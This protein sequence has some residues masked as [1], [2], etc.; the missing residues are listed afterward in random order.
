MLYIFKN[1]L[2]LP[3]VKAF[4][5]I[6]LAAGLPNGSVTLARPL[7]VRKNTGFS[8]NRGERRQ[9]RPS[10]QYFNIAIGAAVGV[11]GIGG[12]YFMAKK[13]ENGERENEYIPNNENEPEENRIKNE[14]ISNNGKSSTKQTYEE[15]KRVIRIPK[16]KLVNVLP[17]IFEQELKKLNYLKEDEISNL[18][19]GLTAEINNDGNAFLENYLFREYKV[20]IEKNDY[21]GLC[22]IKFKE[23][24]KNNDYLYIACLVRVQKYSINDD[25]NKMKEEMEKDMKKNL[26]QE[27]QLQ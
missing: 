15:E 1:K 12:A 20:D 10:N 13:N 14:D 24:T 4:A 21:T 9:K 16:N 6:L 11:F 2:T 26:D 18:K 27:K 8:R 22:M 7:P 19:N 25:L 3:K 5:F 23:D 17:L